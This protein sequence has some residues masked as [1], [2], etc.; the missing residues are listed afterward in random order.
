MYKDIL[1]QKY[2]KACKQPL[3]RALIPKKARYTSHVICHYQTKYTV[4]HSRRKHQNIDILCKE[5][6]ESHQISLD[7]ICEY[8]LKRV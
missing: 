1:R 5:M 6:N 2:D 4:H 3:Q 8:R 7:Y